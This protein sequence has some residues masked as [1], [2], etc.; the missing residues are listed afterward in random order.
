MCFINNVWIFEKISSIQIISLY[1]FWNISTIL[2][3]YLNIYNVIFAWFGRK[4][5]LF[6]FSF[7]YLNLLTIVVIET[8]D[9]S[10]VIVYFIDICIL[11]IFSNFLSFNLG[12]FRPNFGLAWLKIILLNLRMGSTK[13]ENFA[14]S[15]SLF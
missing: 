14:T 12:F 1:L 3:V 15:N 9:F 11:L 6:K 8:F 13:G 10:Y 5:S 2:N 7:E 4:V